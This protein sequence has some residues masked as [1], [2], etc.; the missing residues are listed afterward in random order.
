MEHSNALR[1]GQGLRAILLGG[2]AV[3]LLWAPP[4]LAQDAGE[5]G[6]GNDIVVTA[7]RR[8]EA[9][10]DVPMSVA[11]ISQDT[12]SSVGVN[13]VRELAN[14]TSGVLVNNSGNF[15]QPAIRG[16]SRDQRRYL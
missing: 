10:E 13:T 7:Q 14:V 3:T 16:M 1:I 15:P 2:S 11:V 12:L 9:I 8:A 5:A 4:A 6:I